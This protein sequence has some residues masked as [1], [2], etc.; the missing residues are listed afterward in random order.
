MKCLLIDNSKPGLCEFTRH[1][2]ILLADLVEVVCCHTTADVTKQINMNEFDAAILS[3]SSLN[4]SEPT[5]VDYTRKSI[6]TL[7]RLNNIPILGICFGMQL[8]SSMYG[9]TVKRLE[10]MIKTEQNI[11]ILSGNVLLGG[12]ECNMKVTL[13]HQDYVHAVPNDFTCFCYHNGCA[14]LIESL[15]Y[16]RFGVQFHPERKPHIEEKC[17]LQNFF[18]FVLERKRIEFLQLDDNTRIQI[19][20]MI[21]HKSIPFISQKFGI[22]VDTIMCLWRTHLQVWNLPAVLV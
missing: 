2:E 14:Q 7:L 4:L 6:T 15:K 22:G 12:Q 16:L 11:H 3:G 13:S 21:G 17:V 1:L 8:I 5:R 10:S 9:G 20:N 19:I 18:K